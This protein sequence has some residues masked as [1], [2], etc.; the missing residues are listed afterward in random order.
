MAAL[1]HGHARTADGSDDRPVGLYDGFEAYRTPTLEQYRGVFADGLVVLDANVLLNLYRYTDQ[2]RDDLLLVLERLRDR[3]WVPH[4]VLVEFWRS[5]EG[6]LR[7][8]R[9]TARTIKE[10]RSVRDKTVGLLRGWARGVSLPDARHERITDALSAAFD[11]A[12]ERVDKFRSPSGIGP[13]GDTG[14]DAVLERLERLLAGRAGAPLDADAYTAAFKEGTR[15]VEASEPPGYRDRSKGGEGAVGDY[16]VWE[17]LLCEAERRGGDVLFVTADVKEDWWRHEDDEPRGPRPEL[18]VELRRRSGGALLML[19]PA[20]LL[21]TARSA[22]ALPVH[23]ASLDTAERVDRQMLIS[24]W[25]SSDVPA[26][27]R[28]WSDYLSDNARRLYRAAATVELSR[29]AGYTL[30]D[31]AETLGVDYETARSFHRTSGRSA[32]RWREE[33]ATE[34]PIRLEWDDYRPD[35]AHGGMRTV[36]HLPIGVAEAIRDFAGDA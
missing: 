7:D 27:A 21:S 28:Y 18:A 2:A 15:R 12:V 22:L 26:A 24:W 3:L 29:G 30:E 31:I 13:G 16:L 35:E 9:D 5:R 36:Y 1:G 32:R 34:E 19:T 20:T 25:L 33:T 23:D 11:N 6:V 10:L 8:P 4:Q 14:T 17:Q